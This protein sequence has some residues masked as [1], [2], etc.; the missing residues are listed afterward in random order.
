MYLSELENKPLILRSTHRGVCRGIG[1]SLKNFSV[2]Y[3][4]CA[5]PSNQAKVDFCLPLQAV[6]SIDEQI[7]LSRLRP[8]FPQ[9]CAR[10]FL[11][12]PVFSQEGVYLGKLT[13]VQLDGFIAT[14]LFTDRK[15]SYPIHSLIACSDAVILRKNAPYPIGQLVPA[16]ILSK[17]NAKKD[18]LVTKSLLRAAI[19]K[20]TLLSLTLSLPPFSLNGVLC[21]K[22]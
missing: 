18:R 1:V 14:R 11:G 3:L 19:E 21:R 15:E 22:A 9:N 4:L 8:A 7:S 12:L 13:E 16:P 2:K 6:E 10:L 5:S 20:G 17:I